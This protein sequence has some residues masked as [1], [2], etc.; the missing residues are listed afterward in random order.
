MRGEATTTDPIADM[1]TRLRN[2]NIAFHDEVLMPSSKLKE[3]LARIL[4]REGYIGGLGV[5]NDEGTSWPRAQ[6]RTEV[7]AR[8]PAHH[9]GTQPGVEAGPR[10]YSSDEVPRVPRRHGDCHSLHQ[11]GTHDRPRGARRAS[12]ARSSA[13]FGNGA[14]MSRIGKQP[15]TIPGAST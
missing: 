7:H 9:L 4:V 1:L 2:A 6:D 3:A 8:P 11:P 12:A 14:P 10:V 13:R 15:I 5:A